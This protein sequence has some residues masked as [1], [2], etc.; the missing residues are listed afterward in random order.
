MRT[1]EKCS[2]NAVSVVRQET[3]GNDSRG[4]RLSAVQRL[5]KLAKVATLLSAVF[6]VLCVLV[7]FGSQVASWSRTGVWESY[8][9]SSVVR[10]PKNDHRIT[11]TTAS[12]N[13]PQS[14][15]SN[16]EAMVDALLDTPTIPFLLIVVAFHLLFYWYLVVLDDERQ[17]L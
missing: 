14:K 17:S 12:V 7:V 2:H 4:V 15:L 6:T 16:R 3:T 11:Y 1:L 8:R 13:K 10:S 9:L 5:V